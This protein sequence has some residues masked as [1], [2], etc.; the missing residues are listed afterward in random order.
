M[1]TI[2]HIDKISQMCND[3][4]LSL[5]LDCLYVSIALQTMY[6]YRDCKLKQQYIISTSKH[7]ISQE[8]NSYGTPLGLHVIA[9]KIGDNSAK[10]TVFIARQDTGKNVREFADWKTKGY[11]TTRIFRLKGLQKGYNSGDNV[12]TYE[13]Y[14]YIHGLANEDKAGI[15]STNGCIGMKNDDII[16][17]YSTINLG[18]FVLIAED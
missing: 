5:P 11:V 7:G 18:A 2:N 3:L 16:E 4:K 13:R 9:D 8:R 15:P 6:F 10:N 12:D 17:L 1:N 14:V